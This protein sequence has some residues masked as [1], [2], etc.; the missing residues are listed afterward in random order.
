MSIPDQILPLVR[1]AYSLSSG[2]MASLT[3][4]KEYAMID[5]IQNDFAQWIIDHS[6]RFDQ[7]TVWQ[8]AW[9]QFWR[10]NGSSYRPP[11]VAAHAKM[12]HIR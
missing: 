10:E 6:D 12:E 8:E 4:F 7:S 5:L 9:K 3:G 1:E 2:T 11:V